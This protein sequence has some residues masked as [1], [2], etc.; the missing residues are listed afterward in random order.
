M[1]HESCRAHRVAMGQQTCL[2]VYV[3]MWTRGLGENIA[4]QQIAQSFHEY[5]L[6]GDRSRQLSTSSGVNS[7]QSKL[8]WARHACM[9]CQKSVFC[10]WDLRC[11]YASAERGTRHGFAWR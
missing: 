4:V 5:S 2:D 9:A 3:R 10:S 1:Q 8:A 6:P 7:G 11:S